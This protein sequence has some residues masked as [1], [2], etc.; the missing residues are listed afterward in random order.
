M[1]LQKE[2][3]EMIQ[4]DINRIEESMNQGTDESRWE[5]FREMDGKYQ[6][7]IKDFYEGMWM[8]IPGKNI[9][10]FPEL[11]KYPD[12]VIDNLKMVK[13]KLE[14]YR[15]KG[16]AIALP[17]VTGTHVN[18][19]TNV[20]ISVTFEQ[21]RSQVMD[22]TSLTENQTQEIL[23]KISEIEKVVKGNLNKKTKWETIKPMLVWL[24]D[25]SFD[26][27]MAILPLLLQIK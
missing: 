26:V 22:M 16:N 11:A 18:V 1:E 23:E 12:Y 10:H 13:A 6:G 20:N 19:T 27:G 5:L 3:L 17:E 25:K 15:Y 7:C 24:A 2:F 14:T 9:L 8:S 4:S 21:V